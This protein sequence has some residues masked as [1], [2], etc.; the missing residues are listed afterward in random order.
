[1]LATEDDGNRDEAAVVGHED[2]PIPNN[3]WFMGDR[4]TVAAYN[5][6]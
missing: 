3:D 4:D 2:I 6:P 5:P 1:M